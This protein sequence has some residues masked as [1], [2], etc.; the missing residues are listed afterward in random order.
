MSQPS[1]TIV[2]LDVAE[3]TD[4]DRCI[5]ALALTDE[6]HS[7]EVVIV[8][9]VGSSGA[10]RGNW[11][12]SVP[13]AHMSRE[14]PDAD[15]GEYVLILRSDTEPQSGFLMSLITT[16]RRAIAE[17]AATPVLVYPRTK[18]GLGT[19]DLPR[20][21][22]ALERC[23]LPPQAVLISATDWGMLRAGSEGRSAD[24]LVADLVRAAGTLVEASDAR[25]V[26]NRLATDARR[27][28]RELTY[29]NP[30]RAAGVVL[31]TAVDKP[32]GMAAM[33]CWLQAAAC[34]IP[35]AEESLGRWRERLNELSVEERGSLPRLIRRRDQLVADIIQES[36]L[37]PEAAA[38]AQHSLSTR[39]RELAVA[40]L[41]E[42]P[43]SYAAA[44][45]VVTLLG[46]N[47]PAT[48]QSPI[49]TIIVQGWFDSRPPRD[50][51]EISFTWPRNHP[52]WQYDFF[53][54]ESAAEWIR[55]HLGDS[56]EAI[57]RGASPVGK[58][59]LFRYAYL[60]ECG[61][62]WADI[63]DRAVSAIDPL[64]ERGSLIVIQETI[65][66]VADNIIVVTPRHPALIAT[67]D[68]AFRNV[69]DGFD[70]SPWLANGPGLFTRKVAAS[71]AGL[72][73]G[74]LQGTIVLTGAELSRY[75]SMHEAL[76][77]KETS[78]AWDV[79]A[80][81]VSAPTGRMASIPLSRRQQS[82][83]AHARS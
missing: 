9:D 38:L 36:V 24:Y 82:L 31:T 22:P 45:A 26:S 42:N 79:T 65:G 10:H 1:A 43:D 81:S 40:N 51:M 11:Q 4:L 78:L 37:L 56:H 67:R 47:E 83:Q 13:W 16:S 55:H 19:S 44:V 32:V 33:T 14:L 54:T 30:Q 49:P 34:D 50:A 74:S 17:G 12:P 59:N 64:L 5:E 3:V 8:F 25:I 6:S 52:T 72:L 2:I 15:T 7:A 71:L 61:G 53:D 28:Q 77:Y 63:D 21:W 58:A 70:E 35:A 48:P 73:P 23:V 68:E 29:W 76:E 75:V 27:V 62:V 41:A 69:S 80:D 66:A 20:D 60:A 57:F 18:I 39:D 46:G